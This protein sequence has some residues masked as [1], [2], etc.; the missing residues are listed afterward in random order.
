LQTRDV[1]VSQATRQIRVLFCVFL[2]V[3][4]ERSEDV[5]DVP[6]FAGPVTREWLAAI[7]STRL[8]P[9]RGMPTTRTGI[10][11]GFPCCS[12]VA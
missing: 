2:G 7:C 10:A 8:V 1:P 3:G 6:Q 11:D 12:V 9:E 5:A 4:L